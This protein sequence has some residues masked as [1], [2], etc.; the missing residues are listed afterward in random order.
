M[1]VNVMNAFGERQHPEKFIPKC[2]KK[3][4]DG[5]K[6]YIHSYPDKKTAGTRFYIHARN[7]AAAVMFLLNNG[8]IGEKYNITGESEVS[9]LELAQFISNTVGKEL[10]YE[11]VNH[12]ATRPGHDLRYGLS[13]EKMAKMGWV[14]PLGFEDSLRNCI[15][16]TMANSHWLNL[17]KWADDPNT[18]EGITPQSIGNDPMMER[19]A[20]L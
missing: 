18:Y 1:I 11:M 13:G 15:R 3:V 5:E 7:I 17:K 8:S 16:W 9:N 10:V 14:P 6:V 20:K 2:I 4:M 12:H 19:A